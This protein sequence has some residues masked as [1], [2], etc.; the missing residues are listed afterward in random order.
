MRNYLGRALVCL[1][2]LLCLVSAVEA[3]QKLQ[4]IA[5]IDGQAI[6]SAETSATASLALN[7]FPVCPAAVF[8]AGADTLAHIYADESG[9][10]KA[11]PFKADPATADWSFYAD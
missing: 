7:S 6:A 4:G 8:S 2:V 11:N 10:T 5:G 3:R 1:G 9:G